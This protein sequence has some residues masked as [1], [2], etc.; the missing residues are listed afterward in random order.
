MSSQEVSL[1]QNRIEYAFKPD[2]IIILN[3][4]NEF[5]NILENF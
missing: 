4:A 2:C 1:I 3:G 5:A